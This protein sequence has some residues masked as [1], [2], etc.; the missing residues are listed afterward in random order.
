MEKRNIIKEI[1]T[2]FHI[3]RTQVL[4][5][6]FTKFSGKNTGKKKKA[7]QKYNIRK[8]QKTKDKHKIQNISRAPTAKQNKRKNK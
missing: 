3:R 2:N 4:K 7:T 6:K 8:F 1:A 5:L